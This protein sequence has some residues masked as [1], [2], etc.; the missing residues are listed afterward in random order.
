MKSVLINTSSFDKK[1][2]PKI[3]YKN[4]NFIFNKKKRKLSEN[5]LLKLVDDNT[6]GII[7]GTEL[8]TKKILKKAKNLQVISRCGTG[9]DNIDSYAY[10][11]KIKI[12]KTNKE[13]INA[14]A[15][16]ILCQI[17]LTL[18]NSLENHINV[19]NKQW[20]KIKGSL[21]QEKTVGIIGY[22]KIGKKLHKLL[23]PFNCRYIIY[24]PNIF[25]FRKL[26]KLTELLK[27]SDIVSLQIPFNKKNKNFI[28]SKRLSF[29]KND[30]VLV[31]CARGGLIDEKALGK[32]LK[33]NKS[34]RAILDCFYS[35]PYY[36]DLLNYKNV[37]LSAHASSYSK[38][39]RDLM[40]KNSFLNCV[41]N[42]VIN[43]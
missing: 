33:K 27:T 30:A 13:P 31:N 34:F 32:K 22:G 10:K 12:F 16:F 23:K 18:K 20:K 3:N 2:I 25:K 11:K 40:E 29:M 14:V 17:L 21:L 7:S 24:D 37:I 26:K 39:T 36:G 5:E 8:I 38:E 19:K 6:V 41:N 42:L 15:E 9:T 28:N 35:E 1:N 4:I 43:A